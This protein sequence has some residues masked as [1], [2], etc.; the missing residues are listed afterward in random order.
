MIHSTLTYSADRQVISITG[1]ITDIAMVYI[2]L[3]LAPVKAGESIEIFIDSP[4]GSAEGGLAIADKIIQMQLEGTKVRCV[5]LRAASA[6]FMIW[7]ACNNR[8]VLAYGKLLF[9]YPYSYIQGAMR[10]KD[11][12]EQ[13]EPSKKIEEEYRKRWT[14]QLTPFVGVEEQEK[15]ATTDRT[16][17]GNTFCNVWAKGFCEVIYKYEYLEGK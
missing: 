4:G 3:Q 7:I 12:Q 5:A 17:L 13:L 1:D 10:L 14:A 15:A 8:V 16:F 6:A 11:F 9:H 2:G